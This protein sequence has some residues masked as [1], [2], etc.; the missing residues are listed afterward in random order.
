[1]EMPTAFLVHQIPTE[2]P[3]LN[4]RYHCSWKHPCQR[5]TS[6]ETSLFY[7][8]LS[9]LIPKEW[10]TLLSKWE[11]DL[12]QPLSDT[13]R[14][15]ILTSSH[16]FNILQN[17]GGKLQIVDQMA[18]YPLLCS[19]KFF[20]PYLQFVGGDVASRRPMPI[21]G[22]NARLFIHIGPLCYTG[23]KR[24]KTQKC[25]LI[26]GLYCLNVQTNSWDH[27]ENL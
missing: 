5:S 12:Q 27:I 20:R 13:Q 17:C 6:F 24:F 19:T 22:G 2:A 9:S 3:T 21:S 10:P 11:R 15:T 8:A 25:L 7:Q 16:L 1:M 18:L 23:S 4:V 26:H 14:S